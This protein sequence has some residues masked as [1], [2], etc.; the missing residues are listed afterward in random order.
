MMNEKKT[1][2]INIIATYVRSVIVLF[3]G[4]LSSRWLLMALGEN[5][6]GLFGLV[7]GLS[8][9]ISFINTLLST[10]VCRFYAIE[11]GQ[12]V[13]GIMGAEKRIV[14]WFNTAVFIHTALP[15]ILL[16]IGYPIGIY[17][18]HHWLVIPENRIDHCIWVFR[19][20]CLACYVGM[21][22][23]PFSAMFIAK[24]KIAE[25]TLYIVLTPIINI[26]YIYHMTLYDEEWLI[27]YACFNSFTT[28]I[29]QLLICIRAFMVFPECKVNKALFWDKG[30]LNSLMSFAGWQC[31]GQLGA[32][33]KGQGMSILGN[34]HYGPEVNASLTV[35]NKVS[36]QTDILSAGLK[37]AFAP[38]ITSAYGAKDYKKMV[39]YITETNRIGSLLILLL[40][41]PLS[42][43]I[44]EIF[45][46]WL[47]EPPHFSQQL[48]LFIIASLVIDKTTSGHMLAVIASGKI[49]LYQGVLG[50]FLIL[51]LPLAYGMIKL[52][53]GFLSIGYSILLTTALCAWGRVYF[54][55]RILNLSTIQWIYNTLFPIGLTCVI[56]ALIGFLPH[57]FVN[58]SFKRIILT[59]CFSEFALIS[60]SWFCVLHIDEK[61][62]I[63]EKIAAITKRLAKVH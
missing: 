60:L 39:K 45:Q 43:E 11:E 50:S 56:T 28:I 12:R 42:L 15:S 61:E 21:I 31:F 59:T 22:S 41:I 3:V 19:F 34:I 20:S 18:I 9:F 47:K 14:E 8:F 51:T 10:A 25:Y 16:I 30:R 2:T 5:D 27:R 33:I 17:A 4:L 62:F 38:A 58:E 23:V 1:I 46:I 36:A 7:G 44:D 48:S 29:V 40:A 49:A 13:V 24:Q 63:K 57:L 26:I 32:L 35:A 55:R 37:T 53:F 54:A 52:G 6:Y